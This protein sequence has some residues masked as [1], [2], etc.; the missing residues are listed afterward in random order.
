MSVAVD[1]AVTQVVDAN[2]GIHAILTE[3]QSL[4]IEQRER[5]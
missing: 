5:P 2:W 1:F 4:Q 3:V